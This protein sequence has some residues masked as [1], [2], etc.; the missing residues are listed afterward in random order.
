[1]SNRILSL[2]ISSLGHNA[3]RLHRDQRGSISIASVFAFI[4][5]AMLLG[6]VMN[7]GNRTDRKVRM[8]NGADAATYSGG[9]TLARSM[10]TIAFT[11]HLL[12][13]VFAMTAY[14]REARDRDAESLTV[15]VLRAWVDISESC[16]RA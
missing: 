1:M 4:F 3:V 8:Q 10:N 6:L 9:V 16:L 13:D 11:N 2:I 15:P 7:I 12:C 14:L 5:L